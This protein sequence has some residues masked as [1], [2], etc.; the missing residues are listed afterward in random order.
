MSISPRKSLVVGAVLS[1]VATLS[2]GAGVAGASTTPQNPP[3]PDAGSQDAKYQP[4][5]VAALARTLGVDE[6]AAVA[7]LDRESSQQERLAQLTRGGVH[8]DGAFVD[9]NGNLTVNTGD[10]AVAKKARAAGLAVRKPA[11][12]EAALEKIH[13]RLDKAACFLLAQSANTGLARAIHPAHSR[14]DGDAMVALATGAVDAD[15][16]H[17]RAVA[18]EAVAAAVRAAV[19]PA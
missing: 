3:R 1:A 15:L 12:G 16:D 4:A 17:V 13:A 14:F 6:Q 9:G 18:T 19:D 8:V 2:V 11:R 7:R 10:A 5:M